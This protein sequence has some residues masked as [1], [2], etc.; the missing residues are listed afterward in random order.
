MVT[1][2]IRTPAFP[3]AQHAVVYYFDSWAKES[4][5]TRKTTCPSFMNGDGGR[6]W[7]DGHCLCRR[8]EK[9]DATLVT[10]KCSI[11]TPDRTTSLPAGK[12]KAVH[13]WLG[14]DMW[15]IDDFSFRSRSPTSGIRRD[16]SIHTFCR[17]LNDHGRNEPP[18]TSPQHLVVVRGHFDLSP[19]TTTWYEWMFLMP[20][21][22]TTTNQQ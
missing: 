22:P 2:G 13:Y 1:G 19:P 6:P 8:Q 14:L 18:P 10:T 9:R 17:S 12:S 16:Q 5:S 7:L 11:P 20:F 15:V 4:T 3:S 21:L